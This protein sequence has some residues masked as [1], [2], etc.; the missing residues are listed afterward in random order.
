MTSHIQ[1]PVYQAQDVNYEFFNCKLLEQGGVFA[2]SPLE[3]G[4]SEVD[5]I[6]GYLQQVLGDQIRQ[7][8]DSEISPST[9]ASTSSVAPQSKRNKTSSSSTSVKFAAEGF[10]NSPALQAPAQVGVLSKEAPE[11]RDGAQ[12]LTEASEPNPGEVS[13]SEDES[14]EEDSEFESDESEGRECGEFDGKEGENGRKPEEAWIEKDDDLSEAEQQDSD[15][16]SQESLTPSETQLVV[17]AGITTLRSASST[18]QKL[19][20]TP[21]ST[22]AAV[23]AR[24]EWLGPKHPRYDILERRY[25]EGTLEPDAIEK[26]VDMVNSDMLLAEKIRRSINDEMDIAVSVSS[27]V[28]GLLGPGR[29]D[30]L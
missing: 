23:E 25:N 16:E 7:L 2:S 29:P 20:E 5:K 1:S 27:F 12:D 11:S 4:R 8:A 9:T 10:E 21:Q 18:V 6:Q 3:P 13:G 30:Q 26:L 15:E 19:S 14:S 22:A 28:T 17:R 24:S